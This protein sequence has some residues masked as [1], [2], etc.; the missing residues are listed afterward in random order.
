MR[1]G[2]S[3]KL[4]SALAILGLILISTFMVILL[5]SS[6]MLT[7]V[8]KRSTGG[9][10]S[11][12]GAEGGLLVQLF[13]NQNESNG[14]SNPTSQ[15]VPLG[16][17]TLRVSQDINSSKAITSVLVTDFRGVVLAA[18]PPGPYVVNVKDQ[19][20]NMNIPVVISAGNETDLAV[21]ISGVAFP[22]VYSEESGSLTPGGVQSSLYVELQ[23]DIPVANVN[24]PV[25]LDVNGPGPGTGHQVNATV[26][27]GKPPAQGTQWLEL[28]TTGMVDAV[29][30]T[31]I[32]LTTWSYTSDIIVLPVGS[33]VSEFFG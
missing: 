10:N 30:A 3:S 6:L 12:A 8:P 19:T 27:A 9:T 15:V 2:R 23:S 25:I 1:P 5:N 20:L 22:L 28:G 4:I 16:N 24:Q 29:D 17:R 11:S 21:T 14:L 7:T 13:T 31:S 33:N 18:F 26:V 32:V